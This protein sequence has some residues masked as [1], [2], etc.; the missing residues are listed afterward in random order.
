MSTESEGTQKNS[1]PIFNPAVPTII[2]IIVVGILG[3]V[4]A[5]FDDI[6]G[7]ML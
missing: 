3:I 1:L 5:H 2:S 4:M 7:S 6:F